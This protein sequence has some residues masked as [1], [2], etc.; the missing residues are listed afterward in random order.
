MQRE[1]NRRHAQTQAHVERRMFAKEPH[2][3][4]AGEFH[5]P[6]LLIERYRMPVVV[7]RFGGVFDRHAGV[8]QTIAEFEILV[9]VTGERFIEAPDAIEIGARHRSNSR[10]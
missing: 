5:A 2:G 10:S 3:R 8:L 1:R 6:L 9:T 7:H 4:A